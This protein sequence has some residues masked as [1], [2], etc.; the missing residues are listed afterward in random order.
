MI[1]TSLYEKSV[2]RQFIYQDLLINTLKQSRT[3]QL[4]MH[5]DGAL[6]NDFADFVFGRGLFQLS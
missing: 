4:T 6:N 5:F 1:G 2:P 3:T